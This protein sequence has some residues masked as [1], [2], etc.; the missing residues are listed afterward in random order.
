VN[1][2]Q[3]ELLEAQD[4]ERLQSKVNDLISKGWTP[5][6][7]ASIAIMEGWDFPCVYIQAMTSTSES[8]RLSTQAE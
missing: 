6:G 3:Y 7:G 8:R 5:L 1:G 4:T 2:L